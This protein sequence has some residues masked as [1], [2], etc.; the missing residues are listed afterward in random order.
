MCLLVQPDPRMCVRDSYCL[1]VCYAVLTL[2]CVC[3]VTIGTYLGNS[4]LTWTGIVTEILGLGMFV[5]ARRGGASIMVAYA[6]TCLGEQLHRY[7]VP[8]WSCVL[9]LGSSTWLA[10]Q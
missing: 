6:L 8:H 1:D 7:R 10:E 5:A 3:T 9:L 2:R 4:R